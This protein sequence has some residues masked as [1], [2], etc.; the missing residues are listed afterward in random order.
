VE[1]EYLPEGSAAVNRFLGSKGYKLIQ[2]VFNV[3]PE[4]NNKVHDNMYVHDSLL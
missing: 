4:N 3:Y 2:K 1:I